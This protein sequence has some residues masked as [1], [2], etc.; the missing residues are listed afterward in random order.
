MLSSSCLPRQTY[1]TWR[2][3]RVASQSAGGWVS[4]GTGDQQ[5]QSFFL[6]LSRFPN[7]DSS[8]CLAGVEDLCETHW[9]SSQYQLHRAK[10]CIARWGAEHYHRPFEYKSQKGRH[11]EADVQSCALPVRYPMARARR[12]GRRPGRSPRKLVTNGAV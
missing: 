5:K 6:A 8:V 10:C 11:H 7:A 2:F 1:I 3:Y 9:S 4:L 12:V